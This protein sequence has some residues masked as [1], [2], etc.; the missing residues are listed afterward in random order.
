MVSFEFLDSEVIRTKYS[1]SC[2]RQRGA[3]M[4]PNLRHL[5]VQESVKPPI[6]GNQIARGVA[7][8]I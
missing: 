2:Q 3:Y 4:P 6:L 8:L 5:Q 1:Y 7:V